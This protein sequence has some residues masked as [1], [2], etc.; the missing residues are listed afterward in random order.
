MQAR[1]ILFI[2]QMLQKVP[3]LG[4]RHA[5]WN[6]NEHPM[7]TWVY[8]K[9]SQWALY[10]LSYSLTTDLAVEVVYKF[11]L[12]EINTSTFNKMVV[13]QPWL[14]LKVQKA[15]A[16]V[17]SSY[18]LTDPVNTYC[19]KQNILKGL[20]WH[21]SFS[22]PRCHSCPHSS[23]LTQFPFPALSLNSF[24][25][26]YN[27]EAGDCRHLPIL[28]LCTHANKGQTI[29]RGI[30]V[31]TS[32]LAFV[33]ILHLHGHGSLQLTFSSLMIWSPC[34]VIHT[35]DRGS[36]GKC[37]FIPLP[38]VVHPCHSP[39]LPSPPQ[40]LQVKLQ[41]PSCSRKSLSQSSLCFLSGITSLRASYPVSE[42]SLPATNLLETK[43]SRTDACYSEFHSGR[44]WPVLLIRIVK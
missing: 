36:R 17:H 44:D 2:V 21:S 30:T 3:S 11:H 6:E 31:D 7:K 16:C 12:G 20:K 19:Q 32:S 1:Q 23:S 42:A 13:L 27:P 9:V 22:G 4:L 38:S 8:L 25:P 14:F 15:Q 39:L 43:L 35:L 33:L 37:L 26:S 5:I 28:N 40:C 29:T 24:Y 41:K 34:S 10:Q 18:C